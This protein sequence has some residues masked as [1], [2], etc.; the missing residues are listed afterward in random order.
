MAAQSDAASTFYVWLGGGG[1]PGDLESTGARVEIASPTSTAK[2]IAA[3]APDLV[4]AGPSARARASDLAVEL[5]SARPA[6]PL[7][8]VTLGDEGGALEQRFGVVG[9]LALE[10]AA[11][12]AS[13]LGA[14]VD[15]LE[16]GAPWAVKIAPKELAGL[17]ARALRGGRAGLLTASDPPI[18]VALG[19]GGAIAPPLDAL[20]DRLAKGE[21]IA[22]HERPEGR[23]AVL[24]EELAPGPAPSL[25]GARIALIGSEAEQ[26][27]WTDA[28]A[29]SGAD[30]HGFEPEGV[31]GARA[32]DPT[33][34]IVAAPA[35]AG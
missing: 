20:R 4:I 3:L 25:E 30:V 17:V 28:L 9:Q 31:E 5:R 10:P 18:A 19:A 8:I 1:T 27:A 22:F 14:V 29:P 16:A 6:A 15:E 26:K 33:L 24:S 11:T 23:V 7:A 34:V 13:R 2:E 21:A 35:L 32:L 12:L